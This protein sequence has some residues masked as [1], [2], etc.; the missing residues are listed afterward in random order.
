MANYDCYFA[1]DPDPTLVSTTDYVYI[2]YSL[3]TVTLKIFYIKYRI[4]ATYYEL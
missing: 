4:L 2:R 3:T 1:D